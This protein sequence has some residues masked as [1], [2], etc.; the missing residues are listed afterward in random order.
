MGYWLVIFFIPAKTPSVL[1]TLSGLVRCTP[2]RLSDSN[3]EKA[4]IKECS[5]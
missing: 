4:D 1:L 2:G 3:I 5:A